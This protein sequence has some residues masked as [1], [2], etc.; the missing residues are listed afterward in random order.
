MTRL[1]L[2]NSMQS[3]WMLFASFMFAI[4]GVC[5]KLASDIYSTSELVMYRGIAGVA[6]LFILVR[7]RGG[8]FRTSL[9]WH[10]LWR[11]AVGVTSLLLWFYAISELPLA[12]ATTL[13]YMAPIWIAAILF[14]AGLLRRRKKFEWGLSAAIVM[15]FAGVTLLLKP[16]VQADQWLAGLMGLGSGFLSALAYLAVKKLGQM[17]EPEY[18][19]VFYFSLTGIVAGML[20]AI[21]GPN[22]PGN[23]GVAWHAHST[24]GVILLLGVGITATVAQMAMTRAYRLGNTLVT[25][26]LQYA[27][28]LFSS[29]W[30]F[31]I[32]DDRFDLTGWLGIAV[33]LAS[34]LTATYYNARN[35]SPR[36]AKTPVAQANDPIATEV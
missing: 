20:G 34:G 12:T 6:F 11:G 35:A 18:R 8:S 9:P 13:N 3:L 4:M 28:I 1:H 22:F 2:S 26:N 14:A 15:S 33:I 27:G 19:V 7:L 23:D 24:T 32:W 30:G 16:S 21:A 10:H 36:N 5:V 31:L 29:F 25:A 17:G